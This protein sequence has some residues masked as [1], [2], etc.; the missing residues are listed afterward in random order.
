MRQR[1]SGK[2]KRS[3]RDGSVTFWW[4]LYYITHPRKNF[5]IRQFWRTCVPRTEV[6]IE[7]AIRRKSCRQERRQRYRIPMTVWWVNAFDFLPDLL[8]LSS[9]LK[10]CARSGAEAG[11][12]NKIVRVIQNKIKCVAESGFFVFVHMRRTPKIHWSFWQSETFQNWIIQ[13]WY[14]WLQFEL[15][16]SSSNSNARWNEALGFYHLYSI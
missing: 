1:C 15:I 2:L 3:E 7:C 9:H 4:Q 14:I 16:T 8:C 5:K 12:I 11:M 6:L 13:D 10:A